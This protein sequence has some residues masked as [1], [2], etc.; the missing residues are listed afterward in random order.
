MIIWVSKENLPIKKN[1]YLWNVYSE[2]KNIK[3]ILRYIEKNSK[4]IINNI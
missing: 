2:L 4:S 1:I 3:S